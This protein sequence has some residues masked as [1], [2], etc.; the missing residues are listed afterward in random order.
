MEV[1][2]DA[3]FW[4]NMVRV[5]AAHLKQLWRF[6][7]TDFQ[8][9]TKYVGPWE[10]FGSHT[11]LLHCALAAAQCIVIGPVCLF[12]AGFCLWVGLLPR[13]LEIGCI[14]PHQ[15][16]FVDKGPSPA[17]WI[18]A[19]LRPREGGLRRGDFF[20][21]RQCAVFAYLW[22]LFFHFISFRNCI[23]VPTLWSKDSGTTYIWSYCLT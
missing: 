7:S 22:A 18:L 20:W 10:N 9:R 16:G 12:V 4:F 17:D 15:T 14:D 13:K 8:P 6:R 2:L 21:L 3:A 19:V 5:H 1:A 11:L 23:V